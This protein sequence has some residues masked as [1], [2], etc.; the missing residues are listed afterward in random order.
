MN[1]G[2][3]K[4]KLDHIID[5]G[6]RRIDEAVEGVI[7]NYSW[8]MPEVRRCIICDKV[9]PH[10]HQDFCYDINCSGRMDKPVIPLF[11]ERIDTTEMARRQA[12]GL[13][14]AIEDA[15]VPF[16]G[17]LITQGS[18]SNQISISAGSVWD[19][20]VEYEV[21]STVMFDGEERLIVES[22]STPEKLE[23]MGMQ[24]DLRRSSADMASQQNPMAN[25]YGQGA[26]GSG[27]RGS[28]FGINMFGNTL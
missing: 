10:R 22:F 3:T 21:G 18:T 8:I 17:G 4:T 23:D 27:T 11:K 19:A 20:C 7:A 1:F 13:M 9:N 15:Q 25:A 24:G 12:T 14:G 26:G 28:G 6:L 5:N 2:N 16:T